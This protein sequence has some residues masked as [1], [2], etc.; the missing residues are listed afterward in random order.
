MN[1]I[2]VGDMNTLMGNS[3]FRRLMEN[4]KIKEITREAIKE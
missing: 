1:A 3:K 4:A 2:N